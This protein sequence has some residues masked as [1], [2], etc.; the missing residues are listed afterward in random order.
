L[1]YRKSGIPFL[2]VLYASRDKKVENFERIKQRANTM[3]TTVQAV[4]SLGRQVRLLAVLISRK[5]LER[6]VLSLTYSIIM[7]VMAAGRR[8]D[9]KV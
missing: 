1:Q 8:G 3:I 2:S 6:A 7:L 5:E 4:Q 9:G